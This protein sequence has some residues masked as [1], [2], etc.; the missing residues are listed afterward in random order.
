MKLNYIETRYDVKSRPKSDYPSKLISYLAV[1]FNLNK[2]MKLLEIGSGRGDF[3]NA[4][5]DFGIECYGIDIDPS[6]KKFTPNLDI[7]I[8]DITKDI[9]PYEDNTFDVIFQKSVIEHVYTPNHLISESIRVLK[10]GGKLIILTPDWESQYK[11]FYEDVTHCRPYTP[12]AMKET[13]NMFGLNDIKVEKFTQLPSTWNNIF[14][15]SLA[16][17]LNLLFGTKTGRWLSKKTGVKFFRWSVELMILG[18]GTK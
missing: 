5:D 18:A 1:K 13:L 15:R 12:V 11:V 3:L 7:Q 2:G 8:V 14:L 4:F 10:K 9:F 16:K 17:F 6:A